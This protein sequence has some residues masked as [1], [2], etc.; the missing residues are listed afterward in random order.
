M[1]QDPEEGGAPPEPAQIARERDIYRKLL[2]L[3]AQDEIEPLLAEALALIVEIASARRGYLEIQDERVGASAPRFW[4]AHGF[5]EGDVAKIRSAFSQ[6]VIAE[7]IATRQTVLAA[8]ALEDPRFR[9]RRSVRENRIEAVLCA[10]IGIDPPLGVLYLQGRQERGPFTEEDRMRTETFARHIAALVD[11]L[12]IRRRRLD[13][14]DPTQPFR[15]I[16]KVSGLVGRSAAIARVLQEVSLVAPRDVT[17]LLTGPSGTGKTQLARIIHDNGP[18]ALGPFVELN[19]AALPDALLESELFGAAAG[20]HSTAT[21]KVEG[22][23]A[24]AEH[25]TLFLD[26]VGE[27]APAAQSKLLQLL[28]SKEYFPLG[29][30]R[31]VKA[32]IRVIAATNA[33]LKAAVSRR[34]F[35]EDLLYRLQVLPIRV[36]SLAERRDDIPELAAHC[37]ARASEEHHLPHLRLSLGTLGAAEEAEW[38]GNVRQLAHAVEAAALRAAGEGVLQ[39]ERRH[40]F[41]ESLEVE[42]PASKELTFQEATRRFQQ[43]FLREALEKSKWNITD[44]ANRLDLTRAHIYNLIRAFGLE[45]RR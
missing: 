39:V 44:T 17:V 33:D 42:G 12:L 25:G 22:K 37:C 23:I 24:A 31:A 16:L 26:E 1:E 11:R 2:D 18:R 43:G 35:R 21:R 30:A 5:S 4:I 20:A 41:P 3:G 45:R 9:D 15:A 6:G 10:P 13:E 14:T 38:P 7:A 36:P 34:A 8:S 28:Q 32:D 19:C 29:S 40:L 27:L